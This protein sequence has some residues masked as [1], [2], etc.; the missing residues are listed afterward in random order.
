MSER[1]P[2]S[3]HL[4]TVALP[5]LSPR[6]AEIIIDLIGQLQ[7]ALWDAYGEAILAARHPHDDPSGAPVP[8][9]PPP[10]SDPSF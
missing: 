4:G 2:P 5:A 8:P 9:P 10:G 6:Q 7:A 1:R 3:L